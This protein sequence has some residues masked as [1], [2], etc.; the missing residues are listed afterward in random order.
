MQ[1]ITRTVEIQT[2][3]KPLTPAV[4]IIKHQKRHSLILIF[5][6]SHLT[7]QNS[8]KY[9]TEHNNL[10]DTF[11]ILEKRNSLYLLIATAFDTNFQRNPQLWM[12]T[13]NGY[14]SANLLSNNPKKEYADY[15]CFLTSCLWYIN[16]YINKR[17]LISENCF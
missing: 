9:I 4:R 8:S 10:Q 14:D 5:W 2:W 3:M 13:L 7:K 1:L 15:D 16:V 11:I 17:V 12:I 6:F